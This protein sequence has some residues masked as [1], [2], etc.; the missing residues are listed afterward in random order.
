MAI[1]KPMPS[2]PSRFATGT[3]AFSKITARVGCAFQPILR[4]LA[5]KR[6]AGRVAFDHERRDAAGPVVAGAHHHDVEVAAAGAGDE[7]LLCR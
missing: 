2:S 3:R 1:L 7:L 6:E 5:P 4:S